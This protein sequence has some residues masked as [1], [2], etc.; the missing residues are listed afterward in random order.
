[1]D[2]NRRVEGVAVGGRKEKANMFIEV[3]GGR[4]DDNKVPIQ[5]FKLLTSYGRSV[6]TNHN[7]QPSIVQNHS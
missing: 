6:I 1:M 3:A 5:I 4:R 7:I 2:G